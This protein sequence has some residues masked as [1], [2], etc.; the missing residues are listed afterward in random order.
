[1]SSPTGPTPPPPPQYPPSHEQAAIAPAG[2]GLS[3]PQRL[4]NTFIAPSKT[5]E[6]IKR[7][8]SWWVPWLISAVFA[9]LFGVVVI[10]KVDMVHLVQH[11]IDKSPSAQRRMEQATPAQREQGI[12]LQAGITKVTFYMLPAFSL[13]GGLIIA[14]I[15]MAVFN[16][17]L[18]AE[19]TFQRALAITFY[20]FLPGIIKSILLCVSL[21]A[22][23]DPNTIDIAGNPMPTNPAFFM[24]PLGNKFLYTFLSYVDIF[25][26]WYALLLGLGF[27]VSSNRKVSTSSGIAA[28][29]TAYAVWAL[30]AA[31]FKSIF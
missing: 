27:A 25:A 15:L 12:A 26:V 30:G 20:A 4:I 28:V 11:E 23:S 10:Q 22:S 6:D 19:V 31:C 13:L 2:P 5:F 17:I 14:G 3:E 29:L 16:F 18:G 21:L 7:N 24:D 9:L 1:M 8:A